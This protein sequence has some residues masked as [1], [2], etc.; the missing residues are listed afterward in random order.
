MLLYVYAIGTWNEEIDITSSA[1][2]SAA[3]LGLMRAEFFWRLEQKNTCDRSQ[4]EYIC[5]HGLFSIIS[6]TVTVFIEEFANESVPF[7]TWCG[8]YYGFV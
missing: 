4:F 3:L 2:V 8:V 6:S 1:F 7:A 5:T